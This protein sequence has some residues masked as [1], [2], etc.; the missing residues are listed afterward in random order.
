MEFIALLDERILEALYAVRDPL[1][2]QG[3]IWVSEL[4]RATTVYGLAVVVAL[5]LI[6]KRHY[7]YA[8][9]LA[10]SVT[11]SGLGIFILKGLIERTRPAT[12]Y[13]AYT[14]AWYSFPSAHTAL[15]AALYGFLI[16]IVWRLSPSFALRIATLGIGVVMVGAIAI[17]RLY[18]GVHFLT[19]V[20]VGLL[21]GVA[22]VW[23]GVKL[24]KLIRA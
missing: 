14:E 20:V 6:L 23:L 21:L 24:T 9:G 15:A 5:V 10:T 13:Q 2:V 8:V 1:V 19:D 11:A 16:Y 17:S 4:G 12:V 18:L 3:L 7:A 22:C